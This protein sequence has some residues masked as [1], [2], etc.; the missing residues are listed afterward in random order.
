MSCESM[1]AVSLIRFFGELSGSV[2]CVCVCVCLRMW[3]C[4][5][6]GKCEDLDSR[7]ESCL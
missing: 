4:V 3:M 2:C 1:L 5:M 6:L 7:S